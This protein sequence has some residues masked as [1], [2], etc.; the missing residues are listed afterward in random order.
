MVQAINDLNS[1]VDVTMEPKEHKEL[2]DMTYNITKISRTK[3]S[4]HVV[5]ID[6]CIGI[7]WIESL[8][9]LALE[10]LLMEPQKGIVLNKVH[11]IALTQFQNHVRNTSLKAFFIGMDNDLQN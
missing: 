3:I 7:D 11:L 4:K 5:I 10:C 8:Q 1:Q 2:E 9:R 6:P